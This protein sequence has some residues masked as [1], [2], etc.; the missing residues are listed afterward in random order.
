M[1]L[2]HKQE[3]EIFPLYPFVAFSKVEVSPDSND[4]SDWGNCNYLIYDDVVFI[5]SNPKY[6]NNEDLEIEIYFDTLLLRNEV[7]KNTN[8]DFSNLEKVVETTIDTHKNEFILW[9][10]DSQFPD[11]RFNINSNKFVL[12]GYLSDTYPNKIYLVLDEIT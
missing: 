3:V 4:W 6:H 2:Y 1:K 5:G 7:E 9:N 12:S 11:A 8:F 10:E